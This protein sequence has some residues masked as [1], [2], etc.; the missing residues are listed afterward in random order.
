VLTEGVLIGLLSLP[1]SYLLSW[2]LTLALGKAV[3]M[4][5]AGVAPSPVYLLG[6]RSPGPG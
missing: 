1:L 3:V 6:R 4:G 5:I 2:P